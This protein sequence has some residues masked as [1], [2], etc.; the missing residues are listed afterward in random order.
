MARKAK[1]CG[2]LSVNCKSWPT[3]DIRTV[4]NFLD[5]NLYAH[6]NELVKFYKQCRRCGALNPHNL[7]SFCLT[8][9]KLQPFSI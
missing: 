3:N 9:N 5:E 8:E 2:K 1:S 6:S 4:Y 7:C